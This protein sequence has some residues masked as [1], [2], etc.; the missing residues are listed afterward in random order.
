MEK[1]TSAFLRAGASLVPSPV[2]ATTPS[3]YWSPQTRRSLSSGDDLA[4]TFIWSLTVLNFL[5]FPTLGLS[6]D[7]SS[8]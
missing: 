2:T 6:I 5:R 7:L 8:G 1:P 4:R 3:H